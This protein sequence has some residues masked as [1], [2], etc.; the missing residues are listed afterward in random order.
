MSR[1][2]LK[3]VGLLCSYLPTKIAP[4]QN[5]FSHSGEI[6]FLKEPTTETYLHSLQ[7]FYQTLF[8]VAENV[9]KYYI[10]MDSNLDHIL[11]T[12]KEKLYLI[13]KKKEVDPPTHSE[14]DG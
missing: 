1:P 5:F 2:T 11:S 7:S 9:L 8:S 12:V 13:Q 3:I 4:T 10:F 6:F 14:I